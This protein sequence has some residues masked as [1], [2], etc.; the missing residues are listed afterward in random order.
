MKVA[1]VGF[2]DDVLRYN[3]Q[4][5]RFY[6]SVDDPEGIRSWTIVWPIDRENEF[7]Q[8]IRRN[9]LRNHWRQVAEDL[10]TMILEA[11][12]LHPTVTHVVLTASWLQSAALYLKSMLPLSVITMAEAVRQNLISHCRCSDVRSIGT[13]GVLG[14]DMSVSSKFDE[15]FVNQLMVHFRVVTC[16][17]N[18][19][20]TKSA[21][22]RVLAPKKIQDRNLRKL[23]AFVREQQISV[24][25]LADI[26]AESSFFGRTKA[27][28]ALI[29]RRRK[30]C[31]DSYRKL[32]KDSRW[33]RRK[34]SNRRSERVLLVSAEQAHIDQIRQI[35]ASRDAENAD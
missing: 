13:V 19:F 17:K 21:L 6:G 11:Y 2:L 18:W 27:E 5:L 34:T 26:W 29:V 28:C 25:I 22:G 16:G 15:S 24:I 31:L 30:D 20:E 8:K 10:R 4:L 7:G 33:P 3:S 9:G 35:C 23:R 12:E 32:Q 14:N 1:I